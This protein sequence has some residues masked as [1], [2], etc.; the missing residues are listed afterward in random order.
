MLMNGE[1]TGSMTN[2]ELIWVYWWICTTLGIS[3]EVTYWD[4]ANENSQL[5]L[6]VFSASPSTLAINSEPWAVLTG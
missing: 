1:F 6:P 3:N 4:A 5:R 2:V